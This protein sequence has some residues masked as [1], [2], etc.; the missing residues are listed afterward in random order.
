MLYTSDAFSPRSS[1]TD[2]KKLDIFPGR[3]A[4]GLDDV[5]RQRPADAV[6]YRHDI[7]Q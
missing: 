2:R 1:L 5:S 6:E 4:H 3:E 7:R